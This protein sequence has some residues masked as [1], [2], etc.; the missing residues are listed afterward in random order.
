MSFSERLE[1]VGNA[2]DGAISVVAPQYAARRQAARYAIRIGA[3]YFQGAKASRLTNNWSVGQESADSTIYSD[4]QMLRDRSRDLNRNDGVAAGITDTICTNAIHTG[5]RPQSRIDAEA[6]NLSPDQAAVFQK[7][8]EKVWLKWSGK[9]DARNKLTFSEIESL[10]LRQIIESGEFLAIRRAIKDDRP[11]YLALD[12]IEPDRLDDP[13][14]QRSDVNTRFGITS[15]DRGRPKK[16]YIRKTHPGDTFRARDDAHKFVA[17][18][19]ED[20][21]GRKNVFHVFPIL[22]P[23]QTRGVP[24]FAPVIEKFKMLA[25]Y[26]EAELVAARVAACFSAFVKTENPYG[27]AVGNAAMTENS[28]RL[29]ALEPGM[30]EYLGQNQD[31]TFASPNRPGDTFDAFVSRILRMIGTAIGLPYELVLKDFSQT[32]YSSARAAL[33]QAY[34]V[35]QVWQSMIINHICQPVYELLIEEAWLRGELT[36]P[37]FQSNKWEYTR[38]AWI[39]P[40]WRW[41]DPEKEAKADKISI[42]MGL[43]TRADSCSEQGQDWEEKAEQA[44]KEKAKYEELGLPWEGM[45]DKGGEEKADNAESK[46]DENKD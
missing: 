10:A 29:E 41:V 43:K 34:R 38:T 25:D 21:A 37:G 13:P 2:V 33:L 22:R 45:K 6:L 36:A 9:C 44:A 4:L 11:Y 31:V 39:P 18:K 27:A 1:K 12:I 32:N 16:Y 19:A 23:G 7:Q 17:V 26:L 3:S 42:Q 20:T 8:A 5:I 14:D 15:D 40:G 28:Q 30:I 24:F 46:A 35:F